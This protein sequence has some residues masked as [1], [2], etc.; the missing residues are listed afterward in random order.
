M[1]RLLFIFLPLA[2]I[3]LFANS[4]INESKSNHKGPISLSQNSDTLGAS[5]IQIIPMGNKTVLILNRGTNHNVNKGDVGLIP[6]LNNFK[7]TI[8][9][10]YPIRSKA[11]ADTILDNSIKKVLLITKSN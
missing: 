2:L 10:V 7:L 3:S 8:T 1:A 4:G 9:E 6:S 5:I 11:I